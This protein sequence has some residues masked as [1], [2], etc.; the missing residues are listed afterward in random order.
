M[1]AERNKHRCEAAHAERQ[2]D[3]L[4]Q[5]LAS[6]PKVLCGS[7][8]GDRASSARHLGQIMSL[9]SSLLSR[10]AADDIVVS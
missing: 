7:T 6:V 9:E 4:T 8:P 3:R 10:G 2:A 1:T 5:R